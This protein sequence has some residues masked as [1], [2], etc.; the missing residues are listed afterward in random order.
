MFLLN[1]LSSYYI[2]KTLTKTRSQRFLSLCW[3][4]AHELFYW[5]KCNN[6]QG[7][8]MHISWQMCISSD[9]DSCFLR[10]Q[11]CITAGKES[12]VHHQQRKCL[13]IWIS[14]ICPSATHTTVTSGVPSPPGQPQPSRKN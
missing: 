10:S 13:S 7:E 11:L 5:L 1:A 14:L 6:K 2:F 12:N 8:H 3:R 4:T 9:N